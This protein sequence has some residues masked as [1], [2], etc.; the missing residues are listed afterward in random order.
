MYYLKFFYN[1]LALGTSGTYTVP[2]YDFPVE[3][4]TRG[5]EVFRDMHRTPTGNTWIYEKS[6]IKRWSP[7]S[8]EDSTTTT[9]NGIEHAAHGWIGN[10]IINVLAFGTCNVGTLTMAE[11]LAAG[12]IWGTC[13]IEFDSLPKETALDLWT[14]SISITEFGP[15]QSF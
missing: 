12:Q 14:F 13:F 15:N 5:Y 2:D 10:A 6:R 9:K 3:A 1:S 11:C 4:N 8:F 7:M